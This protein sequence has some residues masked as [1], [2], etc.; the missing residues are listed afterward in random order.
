MPSSSRTF[1]AWT[2]GAGGA[3]G[4]AT[5]PTGTCTGGG[6]GTG[7]DDGPQATIVIPRDATRAVERMGRRR[8]TYT[9]GSMTSRTVPDDVAAAI[10]AIEADLDHER[11][12][13]AIAKTD[14]IDLDGLALADWETLIPTALRCR[15]YS[16]EA[17]DRVVVDARR[18]LPKAVSPTAR[19]QLHAQIA[20]GLTA[21]RCRALASVAAEACV[22][23]SPTSSLGESVRGWIATAFDDR[24]VA[25]AAYREA[26]QRTE[27]H[28]GWMGLARVRYVVGDFDGALAALKEL[29]DHPRTRTG[30]IRLRADVA[31]V[32]GDWTVFLDLID[33][34][35]AATEGGDAHRH[36]QLDRASALF[37]L[38]R[39]DEG[40]EVYRALWRGDEADDV[41]RFAR[42]VLNVCERSNAGARRLMLPR[43][44]TVTQKRNYCG[45]ASLELVLRSLG[46]DVDQDDIAPQVKKDRGSS[47]LAMTGYLESHGLE[48]RRFEGD[49]HRFRAC[50]E[51]GLPVIVE[52]EY[53]TTSH[54]AVVIGV[55]EGL[56]L[57][58]VQDPMTHVTSERLLKTQGSLGAMYRNAAIVAIRPDDEATRAHLDAAGVVDSPH[59][60]I[61]DSCAD[62]AIKDDFEEILRRCTRALDLVDDYPL[63]WYRRLQ[64]L[65]MQA[66]RVRTGNN[67]ARFTLE[68]R[69]A[70]VRYHDQEWPHLLHATFLMDDSRFEEALIELE[71]ALRIDPHDSNNAQDVAECHM[72]AGR[73]DEATAA[74]WKTLSIDPTHVRATENF[75]G[76]CL[77]G[78]DMELAA[79]LVACALE[80]APGNPFNHL[81][82]ARV[83]NAQGRVDD[84]LAAAR[85]C[86]EVAPDYVHGP[87]RL[88]SILAGRDDAASQDE[89]TAIYLELA[90]KFPYWFEPRWRAA[91]RLERAGNING[92]IELLLA[93]LEIAQDDPTDLV[94][95]LTE[96]LLEAGDDAGAVD[97]AERFARERPTVAML[98]LL[99]DV[100]RATDRTERVREATAEFLEPNAK[101][102]FALAQHALS[103]IGNGPAENAEAEQ[104]L[105]AAVDGSPTY[106]FARRTLAELLAIDR[107]EDALEVIAEAPG[108]DDELPVV[109]AG[110]LC[111]LG[112]HAE[113]LAK[114]ETVSGDGFALQD[115]WQRAWLGDDEPAAA[116]ARLP[117]E[118]TRRHTIARFA[119]LCAAGD[120]AG[121]EA[122]LPHLPADDAH[123]QDLLIMAT[124]GDERFRPVLEE[125]LAVAAAAPGTHYARQRYLRSILIGSAAARGDRAALDARLTGEA[126]A[127]RVVDMQRTLSEVRHAP[128]L[129]EIREAL[130]DRTSRPVGIAESAFGAGMRGDHAGAITRARH[131]LE[132]FPRS[133]LAHMVLA[134]ELAM[135]EDLEA[136][137]V[138]A[139]ILACAPTPLPGYLQGAALV[140]LL[141]GD[142]VAAERMSRRAERMMASWGFM[143]DAL[144]ITGAVRA[145]LA[146]DAVRL[147]SLR[148]HPNG[149]YDPA[150]PMWTRLAQVARGA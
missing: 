62:E 134:V 79:H 11:Y 24:D 123:A 135:V 103:L 44:P 143:P 130:V 1:S 19:A 110:I 57:L 95:H 13:A 60:R 149:H 46:I 10:A 124:D 23:A 78:G 4:S 47:I 136:A 82:S 146:G 31:R 111:D 109:A 45:P 35:L 8:Y 66:Q 33:Q 61:V 16:G 96:I 50:I 81:T 69:R 84:A 21:K 42:E 9:R 14:Q 76:H 117:A 128:L 40:V 107:P 129:L 18:W 142:R 3:T 86:V 118:P 52:E 106:H 138:S 137:R 89:A 99:W 87:L 30:A 115:T 72:Q 37:A 104:L 88:A 48:T 5:G 22:E 133:R 59:L 120:Y 119:F 140:A 12:K 7:R 73:R 26:T 83:A 71:N 54:V 105:R 41:G 56:G 6:I 36:D 108:G 64:A 20:Y 85:R 116:A 100:L 49:A 70:R 101:S 39:R 127:Q 125:R 112:R 114:L 63:A 27:P 90:K 141:D 144:P 113:A 77:D 148:T 53:S 97:M 28:R 93:G 2:A 15:L 29:G 131:C 74:F 150:S 132:L 122:L 32:R 75:A 34:L 145:T 17:C 92:A 121:A 80:M 55:D 126:S 58:Y 67:L 25:E 98:E 51:R 65:W 147:E 43:F 68:L 102:P 91:R 94:R 139:A 38:D